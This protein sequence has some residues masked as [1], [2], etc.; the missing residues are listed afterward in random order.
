MPFRSKRPFCRTFNGKF[1]AMRGPRF[2][3]MVEL[4]SCRHGAEG[5]QARLVIVD[6]LNQQKIG[7]RNLPYFVVNLVT[8]RPGRLV[9]N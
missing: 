8:C 6:A 5:E 9:T 1:V 7:S 4:L 2:S 3:R